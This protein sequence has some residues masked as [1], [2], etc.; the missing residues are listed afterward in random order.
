MIVDVIIPT[1]KPDEKLLT[2]ISKLRAQTLA[3]NRIVLVNTEQKYLDN[4]LRGRRYDT[5]GKYFEVINISAREFDHGGTR[6]EGAK[7]S[8]ADYLLYLT[9]DALP[10]DDKMIETMVAAFSDPKIAA[11]YAR[12]LPYEKVTLGERF[13][14]M[15]NYP[16]VSSVKSIDDLERLGIKTFFCSNACA[17]YKREIFERLGRFP[18]GMIF[19]EDMVFAHTLMENGY[20]IAYCAEACV[21]HSHDHTN[22]QQFHR[23]FDLAVS[24]AMHPEVFGGISSESEGRSYAKTAFEYFKK[25]GKPLYFIPFALTCAYRLAGYKLGRNYEKLTH[26]QIL[27]FTG[28]RNFFYRYWS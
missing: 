7:G 28:N 9:M 3:P 16:D 15:Y 23:N 25:E 12:Q 1:Y 14:R 5:A 24:Q 18:K 2:I 27:K 22:M 8:T 13:S 26:R 4:L 21:Y 11:V 10:V 20:S 19:N 6:N 17:M